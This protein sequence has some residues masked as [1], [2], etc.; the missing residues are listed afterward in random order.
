MHL[1]RFSSSL[2]AAMV[3]LE[4]FLINYAETASQ[5]FGSGSKCRRMLL[6]SGCNLPPF[7]SYLYWSK[8]LVWTFFHDV[9][10]SRCQ[11]FLFSPNWR[12]ASRRLE[13]RCPHENQLRKT[14]WSRAGMMLGDVHWGWFGNHMFFRSHP[15]FL[16][17][18][19]ATWS[20]QTPS[21]SCTTTSLAAGKKK[22][23]KP[24]V[25]NV[26]K[27]QNPVVCLASL[28]FAGFMLKEQPRLILASKHIGE[29]EAVWSAWCHC[30][31]TWTLLAFSTPT[32]SQGHLLNLILIHGCK[33]LRT[34]FYLVI[35]FEVF[36]S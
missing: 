15:T 23:T 2:P 1:A 18:D 19:L 17:R 26:L 36:E 20:R 4:S 6:L 21:T 30:V 34:Q 9:I 8:L 32:L 24:P 33:R 27:E 12:V 16:F 25:P 35:L 5:K 13:C 3:G 28:C 31:R 11:T 22:K 7:L 29:G 10:V 14:P